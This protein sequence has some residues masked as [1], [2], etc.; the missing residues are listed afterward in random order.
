MVEGGADSWPRET[1]GA[2]HG[3]M[4]RK[5]KKKKLNGTLILLRQ[6]KSCVNF[7]QKYLSQTTNCRQA[8]LN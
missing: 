5:K 3:E 7:Q 4:W 1:G 6:F 2:L 8:V